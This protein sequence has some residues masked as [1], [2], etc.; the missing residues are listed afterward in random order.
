MAERKAFICRGATSSGRKRGSECA[1]YV[2]CPAT[3]EGSRTGVPGPPGIPT[4]SATSRKRKR[5][6]GQTEL[7]GHW[8]AVEKQ[9]K[10][11]G[12][13]PTHDWQDCS[14]IT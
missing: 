13:C 9:S 5:S 6:R 1:G 3:T 4:I 12:V 7:V 14:Y 10:T 11:E 2:T 8:A